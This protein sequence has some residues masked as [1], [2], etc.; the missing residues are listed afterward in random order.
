MVISETTYATIL[1]FTVRHADLSMLQIFPGKPMILEM[2]WIKLSEQGKN[3]FASAY[4]H[5]QNWAVYLDLITLSFFL[6]VPVSVFL[7]IR[8]FPPVMFYKLSALR[9]L[10]VGEVC[11]SFICQ[12]CWY[13]LSLSRF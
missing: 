3:T 5:I 4:M 8:Y 9:T 1:I 6:S 11:I 12:I 10:L 13:L 2:S 7:V